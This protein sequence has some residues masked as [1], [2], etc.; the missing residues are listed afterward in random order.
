MANPVAVVSTLNTVIGLRNRDQGF[1]L[2]EILVV[3]LIIGITLGF[4]LLAFG[5][6]GRQRQIITAAETFVNYV[7]L[8]EQQALLETSTLGIQFHHND[9]D[10]RRFDN[11]SGW[12]PLSNQA[13]FHQHHFPSNTLLHITPASTQGPQIIIHASGDITPFVLEIGTTEQHHVIDVIG[14]HNGTLSLRPV[15]SP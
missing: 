7:T 11:N 14:Q 6:F 12:Q 2:I 15:K 1:T 8:V 5:D 3:V 9:Y 13:M 10:V 4:A